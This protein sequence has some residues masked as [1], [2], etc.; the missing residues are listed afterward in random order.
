MI[1]FGLAVLDCFNAFLPLRDNLFLVLIGVNPK[2]LYSNSI[3]R[4]S[5]AVS[6]FFF[7]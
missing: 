5:F 1:S 2:S 4:M 6:D 3:L 7:S